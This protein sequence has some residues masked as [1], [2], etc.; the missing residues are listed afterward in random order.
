MAQMQGQ[1]VAQVVKIDRLMAK[2]EGISK[3][4][5][6]EGE[7][8]KFPMKSAEDVTVVDGL[9]AKDAGFERQIVR[10]ETG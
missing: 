8:P 9:M 3:E 6:N 5:G 10:M 7:K 2:V 4:L 1:F